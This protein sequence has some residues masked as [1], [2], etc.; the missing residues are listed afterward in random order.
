MLRIEKGAD[1][2][3]GYLIA[4]KDVERYLRKLNIT[5]ETIS[6]IEL[7]ITSPVTPELSFSTPGNRS[8]RN[9]QILEDDSR[10]KKRRRSAEAA[11]ERDCR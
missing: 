8:R 2:R 6:H 10:R 7:E 3:N 9:H 1:Y 11:R 4:R 5:V